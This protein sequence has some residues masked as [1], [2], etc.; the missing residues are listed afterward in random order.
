L[1]SGLVERGE[2][3]VT[4]D[5]SN[6]SSGVYFYTLQANGSVETRKMVLMK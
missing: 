4:F 5:A 1:V 2:H 6:L 3:R